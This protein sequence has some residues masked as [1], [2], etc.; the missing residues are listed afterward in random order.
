MQSQEWA[1]GAEEAWFHWRPLDPDPVLKQIRLLILPG[2]SFD[3]PIQ[4]R[5]D[6]VS[7]NSCSAYEALSY[8]WGPLPETPDDEPIIYLDGCLKRVRKSL[9]DALLHIRLSD[10]DRYI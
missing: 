6:H 1:L 7:L 4:C 3:D 8:E 5:L 10:R 9:R 2:G